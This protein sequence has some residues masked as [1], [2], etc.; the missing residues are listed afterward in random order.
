[1]EIPTKPNQTSS[2]EI[3]KFTEE[4]MKELGDIRQSYEAVTLALG[5]LY[6][7]K[8]EIDTEERRIN[9]EL[10]NTEKYEKDLLQK[11]LQKYGEGTV[12]PNT[13]VFTP[14]K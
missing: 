11:I 14:K 1:M 10:E 9:A 13:G 4:E 12:D 8:R 3:I 6:L 2:S 5:R 7:Q